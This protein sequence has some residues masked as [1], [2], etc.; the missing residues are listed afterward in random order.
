MVSPASLPSEK[1][2]LWP[3]SRPRRMKKEMSDNEAERILSPRFE[4]A[5]M[6]AA[7]K[8]ACQPRK[9]TNIPYI[10]HLLGVAS[11]V[12]EYRGNEDEA[13]AALLHDAVEDQGGN[14]TRQ[15]ICRLF[16]DCVTK[17]VDG[18]TDTDVTP[19]P[20]WRPRKKAYLARLSNEQSSTRFVSA[21]DKLENARAILADYRQIGESLWSRFNGGKEGTFWYYRSL[22]DVYCQSGTLVELVEELDQVLTQIECLAL[23]FPKG[24]VDDRRNNNEE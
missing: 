3:T 8:H 16:G 21:A 20:D 17:I 14:S 7:Q 19:K 5:L 12:L 13:V 2:N 6:Y 4:A 10:A 9:R 24:V 1:S 18:C 23:P 11:I 22:V 15:E